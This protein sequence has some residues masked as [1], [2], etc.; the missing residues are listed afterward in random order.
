[1][2][3]AVH[4]AIN[5]LAGQVAAVSAEDLQ[6]AANA[7]ES[8]GTSDQVRPSL[9]RQRVPHSTSPDHDPR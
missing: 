3:T 7:V 5:V 9:D 6:S 8:P 4:E 1:M 2:T